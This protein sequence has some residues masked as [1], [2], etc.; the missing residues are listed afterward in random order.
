[1]EL[2]KVNKNAIKTEKLH[3]SRMSTVLNTLTSGTVNLRSGKM[4]GQVSGDEWP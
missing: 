3:R 2:H 4:G 1:M